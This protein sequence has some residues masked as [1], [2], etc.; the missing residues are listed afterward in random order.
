VGPVRQNCVHEVPSGSVVKVLESGQ[1][2]VINPETGSM[3]TF[4]ACNLSNAIIPA[5]GEYDGWLA[6]TAYNYP[7]G[8]SSF[9][10][11]FSVPDAP[12]SDPQVLY[13]FTGLQNVNWIPII[14]PPPNVF[15]IIQPVLQ[16]PGDFGNYWSVKSWYVTLNSGV[17]YS[18]EMQ[19][20]TGDNIYGV[21]NQSISNPETWYIAGTSQKS[22]AST[23]LTVSKPRLASQPWGYNTAECYGCAGGCSYEPQNDVS[24]TQLKLFGQNGAPINPVWT[25]YGSPNDACSEKATVVNSQTVT[26]SFQ[27]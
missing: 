23:S 5:P 15:D 17:L 6:Y 1:I 3:G 25:P 21:M 27:S 9:L 20:T 10:G 2:L 26:I 7:A 14:D 11:Y 13:L 24:F 16:Y 4:P 18:K 22:G 19:T 12:Q 8:I